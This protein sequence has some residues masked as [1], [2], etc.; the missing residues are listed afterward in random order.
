MCVYEGR[1]ALGFLRMPFASRALF[2]YV[3]RVDPDCNEQDGFGY[4][5]FYMGFFFYIAAHFALELLFCSMYA[6]FFNPCPAEPGYT[7]FCKQCRSRS[8]GF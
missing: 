7:L 1:W 2:L 4:C 3:R 6:I 5:S 8:V